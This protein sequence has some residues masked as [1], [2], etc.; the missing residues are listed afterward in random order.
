MLEPLIHKIFH[1]RVT[2]DGEAVFE[3]PCKP[4]LD[5]VD[6]FYRRKK[7][8]DSSSLCSFP[9]LPALFSGDFLVDPA[10]FICY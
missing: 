1:V 9:P 2:W 5:E 4:M 10:Q 8:L 6:F 7:M 3:A